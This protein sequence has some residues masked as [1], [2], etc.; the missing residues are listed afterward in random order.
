MIK[1]VS[2]SA[3]LIGLPQQHTPI[4]LSRTLVQ[5]ST[6]TATVR[7]SSSLSSSKRA[8]STK[9]TTTATSHTINSQCSTMLVLGE[10]DVQKTLD[11]QTCLDVN[12]KALI[13]L[14]EKTA[15]IPTRLALSYPNNPNKVNQ[16]TRRRRTK[17][18]QQHHHHQSAATTIRDAIGP[19]LSTTTSTNTTLIVPQDW[20]LIKPAAYYGENTRI[21]HLDGDGS[22]DCLQNGN[23][24]DNDDDQYDDCGIAMGLKV[25]SV[26]AKNPTNG[27]PLVPATIFL[28]DPPSGIVIATVAGTHLTVMRTSAGPALAVKAFQ[29]SVQELVIFGAG[30]QAE[31]HIQLMEYVLQR[32]I[33]KITIINRTIE[34]AQ[35]LQ[36]K[37][38]VERNKDDGITMDDDNSS[39]TIASWSSNA[40]PTKSSVIEVVALDDI[41]AVSKALSTADV[42]SATTNTATPLFDGPSSMITLPKGCLITGIGSYTPDMQEIP[43]FVV[44]R[45]IVII[46]T[47]EAMLVGDLKHLGSDHHTFLD[48][49]TQ[50]SGV[51]SKHPVYLAGDALADPAKIIRQLQNNNHTNNDDHDNNREYIFYKAV[52]TAVQDVLTAQAVLEKANELGIGQ[53]VDMS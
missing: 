6:T 35:V 20:T 45:S 7:L 47:P 42:V 9:T 16:K 36:A 44:N 29:P 43:E 3:S 11:P 13:A 34:R 21:Q 31:C 2:R 1:V 30:A 19:S 23:D 40:T 41:D 46:D 12:R 25:V 10:R 50:S 5:A 17:Q 26:R 14:A 37:L 48:D 33:P 51:A 15:I 24:D 38:Q 28:I 52:G 32:R 27:L 18:Q 53:K 8:S 49:P 39:K 4:R 22:V